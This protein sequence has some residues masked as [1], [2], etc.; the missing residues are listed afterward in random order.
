MIVEMGALRRKERL[1]LITQSVY[2]A[3]VRDI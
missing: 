3:V 2:A 1:L